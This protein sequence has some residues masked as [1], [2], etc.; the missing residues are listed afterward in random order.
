[1]KGYLLDTQVFLWWLSDDPRLGK[2]ARD[3]IADPDK[4]IYVSAASAWEIAIKKALGKL[5]APT[6]LAEILEEE[7]FLELPVFFRHAEY[8]EK[9]PWYH[10]DPFDRMLIA[11]A[12]AEN[13]ILITADRKFEPYG[14]SLVRL[15]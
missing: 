1:M 13:L 6:E 8:L 4:A 3:I 5:K 14:V 9:L 10:K 15:W 7:G 2:V 12:L 11:Q